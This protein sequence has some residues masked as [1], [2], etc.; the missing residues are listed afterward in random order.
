LEGL[1][2]FRKEKPLVERRKNPRIYEPF[3]VTVHCHDHETGGFRANTVVDDLSASGLYVKLPKKLECGTKIYIV[4]RFSLSPEKA[5]RAPRIATDGEVTR[6]EPKPDGL[7]G[8][9]VSFR[10][11][12]FI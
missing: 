10:R 11:Q 4:I 6:V 2:W 9:S 5:L 7:W 1:S 3:P 12:H 8:I